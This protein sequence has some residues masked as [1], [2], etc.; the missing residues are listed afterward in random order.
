MRI[1]LK[2]LVLTN[3]ALLLVLS[4]ASVAQAGLVSAS[5][6]DRGL[7]VS[8]FSAATG[9]TTS[10]P[11]KSERT[12]KRFLIG[13]EFGHVALLGTPGATGGGMSSPAPSG[14]PPPATAANVEAALSPAPQL[15]QWLG[16][17]NESY[18]PRCI[19]SRLFR[20]PRSC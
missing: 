10:K 12:P 15:R 13:H 5:I 7:G 4:S 17:I 20:P 16:V 2:K 11:V 8:V 3:G 1:N 18:R 6:N 9:E 14:S 19:V